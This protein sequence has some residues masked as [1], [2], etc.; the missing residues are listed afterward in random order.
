M[1]PKM[2]LSASQPY[3]APFPGFF[4][5]AYRSDIFVI[6]DDVQFPRGSSWI[7][8]NRFK[9]DQGTLWITIPVWKKGLGLQIIE[10]VRICDERQ[11][12]KKHLLSLKHAYGHAPYFRDHETFLEKMFSKRFEKIIDLN[13]EMIRYLMDSLQIHTKLQ[14]VSELDIEGKGERRLIEVCKRM[15]ADRFL[16]QGPAR[17]YLNAELFNKAEITLEFFRNP[18]PV[19]PQLWGDFIPNLSSFDLLFNCGSKAHD[20]LC[21]RAGSSN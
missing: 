4:Y 2:I 14:L 9:G 17:K 15:K 8:R 7:T 20:I 19:Y 18:S 1:I 11:W 12:R 10:K 21:G 13:L 3:F 16:A 5:K 6:M